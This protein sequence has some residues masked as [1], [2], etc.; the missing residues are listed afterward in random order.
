MCKN[1]PDLRYNH[2]RGEEMDVTSSTMEQKK[3]RALEQSTIN[4]VELKKD[5]GK[6]I[7]RFTRVI[8]HQTMHLTEK[9]AMISVSV[10]ELQLKVRSFHNECFIT[11]I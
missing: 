9:S 6:Y 1:R 3:Q 7:V 5:D 11:T 4:Q 10:S 2:Y 8:S